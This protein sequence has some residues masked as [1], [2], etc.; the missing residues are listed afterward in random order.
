MRKKRLDCLIARADQQSQLTGLPKIVNGLAGLAFQQQ[1]LGRTTGDEL[2]AFG[3]DAANDIGE[4]AA[5]L[6]RFRHNRADCSPHIAGIATPFRI[7]LCMAD[8]PAQAFGTTNRVR[9]DRNAANLMPEQPRTDRVTSFV[10]GDPLILLF[11]PAERFKQII[12]LVRWL[13]RAAARRSNDQFS[14]GGGPSTGRMDRI[15]SEA[16]LDRISIRH[17]RELSIDVRPCA[18][19]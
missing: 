10:H 2:N 17:D 4:R 19:G 12:V 13:I 18:H 5:V 1:P 7:R 8:I 15:L 3:V 14:V 16:I 11:G 6:A 9:V